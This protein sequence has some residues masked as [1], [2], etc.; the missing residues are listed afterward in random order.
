MLIEH[1]ALIY[2]L[3]LMLSAVFTVVQVT[4]SLVAV[5]SNNGKGKG[6]KSAR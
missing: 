6:R 4:S 3:A 1:P 2:M 5:K